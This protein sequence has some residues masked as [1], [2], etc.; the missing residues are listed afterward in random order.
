M[1]TAPE[2]VAIDE[3][4]I[5]H[6]E[7]RKLTESEETSSSSLN[8]KVLYP[9]TGVSPVLSTRNFRL[10]HCSSREDIFVE[11]TENPMTTWSGPPPASRITPRMMRPTMVRTLIM[12][13]QNSIS[14]LKV[15]SHVRK[16][17]SF[18]SGRTYYALVPPKLIAT[19]TIKQTAIQ[20][21]TL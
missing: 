15:P 2:V 18:S 13:N 8:S 21:E 12:A 1:R 17:S 9:R 11:L 3:L 6:F 5:R 19:A 4:R 7:H 20:T 10:S 16:I 14:P